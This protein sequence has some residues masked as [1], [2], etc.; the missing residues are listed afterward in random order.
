MSEVISP[1]NA[2]KLPIPEHYAYVTRSLMHLF[3]EG[4]LTN[5][6]AVDVE[7]KYGYTSRI[8]YTDGSH[9]VTY[10]N[11]LGLN[12][13][14]SEDLA[15]DK[16][17]TK[18]LLRTIGVECPRGE[19]FLLPWWVEAIGEG[20]RKRGNDDMLVADIASGYIQGNL[21]YPVY[22]KPVAGSKGIGVRKVRSEN[23]LEE[24]IRDLDEQ[25]SRVMVVEEAVDMPDYRI[26][27]LDGELISAYERVPL[28]VVG[29]GVSTI[30]QLLERLQIKFEKDGRDTILDMAD[31]R[32]IAQLAR[33]GLSH[34]AVLLDGTKVT[35]AD[36]SNL[37]AGGASVDVTE[38]IAQR[39]VDLAAYVADNFN[40]RLL[41][42]DLA[43]EDIT[44]GLSRYSVLEVNSTPGLDHYAS[45]GEAQKQIVDDLYTRVLN[46]FPHK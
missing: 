21:G 39:W 28:G 6:T 41:G 12:P 13:G 19:E 9:R 35:I 18:F 22:V 38:R 23:E 42:L 27:A 1:D 26:V 8:T 11:D 20:Q 33:Q 2:G 3:H 44:D 46:A 5:V 34:D 17:H 43:C 24:C 37:S 29:D 10:G 15:K 16:G 25:R 30:R 32:H 14:A 45:S 40:L 7:P 36:I 31:P 4:R